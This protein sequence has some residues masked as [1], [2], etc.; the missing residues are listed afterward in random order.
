MPGTWSED[1]A[2]LLDI[3]YLPFEL[4]QHL[5]LQSRDASR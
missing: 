2:L 4:A 5:V 1:K 3:R